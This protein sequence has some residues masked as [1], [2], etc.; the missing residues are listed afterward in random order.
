MKSALYPRPVER[1][2]IRPENYSKN[3]RSCSDQL[4]GPYP[5][6][7]RQNTEKPASASAL[8]HQMGRSAEHYSGGL[9]PHGSVILV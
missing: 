5:A 6:E 7:T 4:T 1:T 3:S 2:T 8:F 9:S